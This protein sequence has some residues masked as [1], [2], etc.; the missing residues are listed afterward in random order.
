M[1]Q[2][3]GIDNHTTGTNSSTHISGDDSRPHSRTNRNANP[4]ADGIRSIA[5]SD[6][7][8]ADSYACTCYRDAVSYTL[9]IEIFCALSTRRWFKQ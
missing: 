7:G 1:F 8:D 4:S 6:T 5:N 2:I 9:V 3:T